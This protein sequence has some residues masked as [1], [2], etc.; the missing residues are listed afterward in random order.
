MKKT[1]ILIAHHKEELNVLE[2]AWPTGGQDLMFSTGLI[3]FY[4]ESDLKPRQLIKTTGTA[5]SPIETTTDRQ[6]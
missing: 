3:N 2:C 5:K 4:I 6:T 1:Q